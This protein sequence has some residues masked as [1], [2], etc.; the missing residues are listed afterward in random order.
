[1]QNTKL[2]YRIS[3]CLRLY[4]QKRPS[5]CCN[6]HLPVFLPSCQVDIRSRMIQNDNLLIQFGLWLQPVKEEKQPKRPIVLHFQLQ[7][8]S[9][10][11][12]FHFITPTNSKC[13]LTLLLFQMIHIAK[14][15]SL[16]WRKHYRF[17]F[18]TLHPSPVLEAK[19]NSQ[20]SG[21]SW[22]GAH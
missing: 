20:L 13:H 22:L 12:I 2:Q 6:P 11:R 15:S 9:G 21:W 7:A 8:K 4:F 14:V 16:N 18:L 5:R 10:P 19:Q 3:D 17:G 1:M